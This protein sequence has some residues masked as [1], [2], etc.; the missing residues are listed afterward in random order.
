MSSWLPSIRDAFTFVVQEV[1]SIPAAFEVNVTVYLDDK[2]ERV[3][4]EAP[5]VDPPVAMLLSGGKWSACGARD[6]D[7]KAVQ[8]G[9]DYTPDGPMTAMLSGHRLAIL[10]WGRRRGEQSQ[11]M[12]PR[13]P[14][15]ASPVMPFGR[16]G[17]SVVPGRISCMN[18]IPVFEETPVEVSS[19]GIFGGSG[20]AG[21]MPEPLAV[22]EARR[23][24][25]YTDQLLTRLEQ[26][27]H[28]AA[29]I[30][31]QQL[32]TLDALRR[33]SEQSE[34][35]HPDQ[36]TTHRWS[37]SAVARRTLVTEVAASLRLPERTAERLI[38]EARMLVHLLPGTF[39]ALQTGEISRRHATALVDHAQSLP[40]EA[41]PAF[42]TEPCPMPAPLLRRSSTAKPASCANGPTPTA[43]T[44]A[45]CNRLRTDV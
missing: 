42:E 15:I 32:T 20:I 9:L 43:S 13:L 38:E 19:P 26:N 7:E 45:P 17:M 23:V 14:R 1:V 33:H 27:R 8:I 25:E 11:E 12:V 28:K 18:S 34:A 31:A 16:R 4:L 40:A 10:C 44:P 37:D 22:H 39:A 24:G 21:G 2:K 30:E 35:L 5:V 41:L 36:A 6:P 3:V 29:A